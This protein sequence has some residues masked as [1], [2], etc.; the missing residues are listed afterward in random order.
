MTAAQCPVGKASSAPWAL[1]RDA[2]GAGLRVGLAGALTSSRWPRAGLAINLNSALAAGT[3]SNGH[4]LF[5]CAP[6]T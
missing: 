3:T 2:P 1:G 4:T 6:D 5:S